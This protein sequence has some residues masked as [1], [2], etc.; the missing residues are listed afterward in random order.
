MVRCMT[1]ERQLCCLLNINWHLAWRG[2]LSLLLI[3][4]DR[5]SRRHSFGIDCIVVKLV[6]SSFEENESVEQEPK[7]RKAGG[8]DDV[9][10]RHLTTR[11]LTS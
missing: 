1:V 10:T 11:R 7:E 8:V 4:E 5:S 9:L 6:I 2:V 3:V